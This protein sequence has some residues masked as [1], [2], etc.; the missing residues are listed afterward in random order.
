MTKTRD[1][2]DLA[3]GITSAN[4]VDGA[5]TNAD[6]N[7]SAAVAS[8]KLAFT[9][10][11]TGAVQRTVESKLQDVV[12]VKDFIPAGTDTAATDCSSYIQAAIDAAGVSGGAI[13]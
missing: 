2:A 4:I 1:L 12:S 8:S 7:S 3:N 6:I 13:Y 5:V 10:S 11:G 9:Q